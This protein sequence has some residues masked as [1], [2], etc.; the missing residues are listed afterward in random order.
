VKSGIANGSPSYVRAIPI[1][2]DRRLDL[3]FR[4]QLQNLVEAESD[5]HPSV[6]DSNIV[7]LLRVHI[8]Q[9]CVWV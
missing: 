3:P 5:S 4:R 8:E 1:R 2:C 7:V 6:V 9:L